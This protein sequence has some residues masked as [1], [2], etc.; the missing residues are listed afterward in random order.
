MKSSPPQ[1]LHGLDSAVL[2]RLL[3]EG[4]YGFSSLILGPGSYFIT[5]LGGNFAE[6][7][8]AFENAGNQ[9]VGPLKMEGAANAHG[10]VILVKKSIHEFHKKRIFECVKAE[11][12]SLLPHERAD[13]QHP[14]ASVRNTRLR[15]P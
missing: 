6:D 15:V 5:G 11:G 2:Q 1:S 9:P 4:A 8:V 12:K 14:P 7:F 3:Q 13:R 10:F